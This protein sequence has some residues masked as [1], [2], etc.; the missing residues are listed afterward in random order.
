MKS[1]LRIGCG[2]GFWGDSP[3]GPAQLIQRGE[4][5]YLMLDYLAEIT[6]SIMAGMRRKDPKQGYASDFVSA[7]MGPLAADIAR[8]GVK[9][10]TNAG[11]MN[12]IACRDALVQLLE[13]QG[14]ELKVGVVLGD[15]LTAQSQEL[16]NDAVR[17]MFTGQ[18]LPENPLSLNAY[19]GA[20]PIAEALAQGCDIVITGR[21]VDSA[22]AL[23][24]LIHEFGWRDTDYDLLAAGSLA[25][26]LIECGA[27]VC[28]GIFTD[29][30]LVP[31]WE[32]AGFP[33][34][35]CRGDGTFDIE[36]PPATGGLITPATVA[37]QLVYEVGDPSHYE[38]PDVCCDF[39]EVKL[40]QVAENRVRVVGARG[41]A[42]SAHYK[43]CALYVDGHRMAFQMMVGG[44]EA[45]AKALRVGQALLAR[46]RNIFAEKGWPDF[47]DT[48]IEPLGAESSYGPHA[49]ARDTREVILRV[50]VRHSDAKALAAF[51]REVV[52]AATAMAQ[53]LTGFSGGR[54]R[55]QPVIRL[56]SCLLEKHRVQATLQIGQETIL[57][58]A[59]HQGELNAPSESSHSPP[60]QTG[61]LPAQ[62]ERCVRVPLMAIA[63]ARSGDKG[64][65][66]NIGVIARDPIFYPW[67]CHALSCEWV[68]DYMAHVA[69]GAI[70]RF[71]WPG[72]HALNFLLHEGLGGGG[73]LSLRNDPQGK[74]LGQMLLDLPIPVP[75][76]W[77]AQG[78]PLRDWDE[79]LH[80]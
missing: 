51:S 67:L 41:V 76:H 40:T 19:L 37:E 25:G 63:H 52:S 44:R 66:A 80:D 32:N 36:K 29:W 55:P 17:D 14:I 68:A 58:R 62:A 11:G 33:I 64:N 10:V 45:R 31:E 69:E 38:L 30:Q 48:L 49:K 54:P 1:Q 74:A 72:I 71:T 65:I 39:S 22:L 12:P 24:P 77:L 34:A 7:V 47:T 79:V 56:F 73:V 43:V 78:G 27:Q 26:H 75:A 15:D 60:E 23:G 2:A 35:V 4:V 6:L 59:S 50:A 53:G 5:D 8:Q 13:A 57:C 9:V 3:S 20:F 21:C 18:A 61:A 16:Q 28:G 42:P 70:E 46:A